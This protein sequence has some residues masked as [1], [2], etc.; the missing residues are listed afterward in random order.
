MSD[1]S[2]IDELEEL[3]AKFRDE[4]DWKKYHN[5]K[6]LCIS[7]NLESSELLELYQWKDKNECVDKERLG[8]E[9][10]DVFIYLLLLS[11]LMDVDLKN[12]VLEKIE[13]NRKKYPVD[14]STVS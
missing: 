10:A 3:V 9:M 12:A 6:D 5:P 2:D 8:E 4:R 1:I 7:L 11:D 14:K 13:K